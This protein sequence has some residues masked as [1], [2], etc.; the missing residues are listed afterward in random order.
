MLYN[1]NKSI[2]TRFAY[3]MIVVVIISILIMT[4]MKYLSLHSSYFDLGVF[5]NNLFLINSNSD[6]G[7]LF[8]GHAQPY[9]WFYSFIFSFVPKGYGS[10]AIIVIQVL[11]LMLPLF[12]LVKRY[13][14]I[15]TVAYLSFFPLWFNLLND[16]HVDHL[17]VP[18]LFYF[19][20]TIEDRHYNK[21]FTVAILL[22]LVKE[23]FALQTIAC[24]IYLILSILKIKHSKQINI[25]ENKKNIFLG[26]VLIIFGFVYFYI[27]HNVV[28]PIVL[29]SSVSRLNSSAYAW[30]GS[31]IMDMIYNI[32]SSPVYIMK[33]MFSSNEKIVYVLALFGSLGFVPL[34]SYRPLLV[35]APILFVS[36]LSQ[37]PNYYG[38]G[39]HYTAGLIAPF[40]FSF[41]YGLEKVVSFFCKTERRGSVFFVVLILGLLMSNIVLSPSPIGRL[42]WSEKIWNYNYNAYLLTDRTAMIKQAIDQIIPINDSISIS[43]QN[44]LNWE[45]LALRNC[46]LVFPQG[47][48]VIGYQNDYDRCNNEKNGGDGLIMADY[49]VLDIKRPWFLLDKGCDWLYGKCTDNKLAKEYLEWVE[50][51]R[52]IMQVVFERDGFIILQRNNNS[53]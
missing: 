39:H 15:Y 20:I 35:A 28:F 12:W 4:I 10:L 48:G 36:L 47:V 26:I 34:F 43:V 52:K 13:S 17:A 38:L 41:I 30:L 3:T 1:L 7:L 21:A 51:T 25:N 45:P 18:L 50:K 9:L 8:A 29:D 5:S 23:V 49:V 40:I 33:E 22:A 16:F 2:K 44:T 53:R 11:M 37:N 46:F 6:F 27:I 19:F 42:F 31:G 14:L 32:V 24:G